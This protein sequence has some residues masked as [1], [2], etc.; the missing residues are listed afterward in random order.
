MT[1]GAV[2]YTA[3][4]WNFADHGIV[5]HGEHE[6]VSKQDATIHTNTVEEFVRQP[7]YRALGILWDLI[8]TVAQTV[9]D[10]DQRIQALEKRERAA[11]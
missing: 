4:G 5:F 9:E 3:A 2:A 11:P 7:T 6:Y 8:H 1:D 10:H